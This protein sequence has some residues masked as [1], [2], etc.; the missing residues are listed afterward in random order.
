M[1]GSRIMAFFFCRNIDKTFVVEVKVVKAVYF[2]LI[3]RDN[4][5]CLRQ[6]YSSNL[7]IREH[8]CLYFSTLPAWCG[9]LAKFSY[10]LRCMATFNLGILGKFY[11][12]SGL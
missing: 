3:G 7:W 4:F 2:R 11:I 8:R 12:P 6:R 10:D 5:F 1:H 9:V